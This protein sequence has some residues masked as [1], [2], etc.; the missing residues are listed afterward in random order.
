[1][2]CGSPALGGLISIISCLR[3]ACRSFSTTDRTIQIIVTDCLSRA[4]LLPRLRF[5]RR[6]AVHYSVTGDDFALLILIYV[7]L[8]VLRA[9]TIAS[10]SQSPEGHLHVLERTPWPSG[11][12]CLVSGSCFASRRKHFSSSTEESA[13]NPSDQRPHFSVPAGCSDCLIL[14]TNSSVEFGSIQKKVDHQLKLA[15]EKEIEKFAGG[16][17]QSQRP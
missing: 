14:T 3:A 17:R 13:P 4:L 16:G 1:M 8:M 6:R 2:L 5:Q 9:V 15:L 10:L 7:M 11:W 12:R